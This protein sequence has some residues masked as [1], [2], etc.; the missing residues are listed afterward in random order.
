MCPAKAELQRVPEPA[1]EAAILREQ[2]DYLIDSDA[3][4]CQIGTREYDRYER[5]R[6]ALLELFSD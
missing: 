2:L 1:D 3:A 6:L 4:N 5:V